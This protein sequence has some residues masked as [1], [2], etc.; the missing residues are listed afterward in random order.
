M[1]ISRY[2]IWNRRPP[3]LR[4]PESSSA[5]LREAFALLNEEVVNPGMFPHFTR[6][7][8]RQHLAETDTGAEVFLGM[9]DGRPTLRAASRVAI[10]ELELSVRSYNCLDA[11]SIP[12]AWLPFT[13]RRWGNHGG[14]I[15]LP[16]LEG[17]VPLA[18][19]FG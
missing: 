13:Q 11:A 15:S 16:L 12:P 9:T 19:L 1:V 6:L 8:I 7:A 3:S 5:V 2:V 10:A 14:E 4:F 18:S 17:S